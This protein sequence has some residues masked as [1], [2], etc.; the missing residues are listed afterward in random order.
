MANT[1]TATAIA[2][3]RILGLYERYADDLYRV[4]RYQRLLYTDRFDL[5]RTRERAAYLVLLGNE[6][7]LPVAV[8]NLAAAQLDD[9]SCE[10]AY[11]LLRD[12]RPQTVVEIS[13]C[14]GWSTSW[15]LNALHDN[16]QGRLLSFDIVDHSLRKV[17]ADLAAGI[18]TFHQGDVRQSKRIPDSID[19]LFMDSDHTAPFAHWYLEHV[20]PR[21]RPGGVVV[22][23]D[24]FHPRGPAES[25]GEGPVVLQWLQQ[26]G[27]DFFDASTTHGQ[28]ARA[29]IAGQKR[30]LG[31]EDP[32]VRAAPVDPAIYFTMP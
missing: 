8:D 24:V 13:P 23:D 19:F 28:G 32:I 31:L 25:G 20:V 12:E 10:I 9:I 17:P 11:L 29:A 27:I 4:R 26:R 7:L 6:M 5:D 15:I 1:L 2:S 16:R 3:E 22:V 21:V 14:G 30:L 18:R